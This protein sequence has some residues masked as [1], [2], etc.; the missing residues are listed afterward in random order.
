MLD[1]FAM[2]DCFLLALIWSFLLLQD[3]C[4]SEFVLVDFCLALDEF[5]CGIVLV[6]LGAGD[7]E[8]GKREG[9][10]RMD[11]TGGY[12]RESKLVL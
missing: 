1:C 10:A 7:G 9:G 5:L 6:D 12:N 8:R 4:V 11:P 2:S 3:G